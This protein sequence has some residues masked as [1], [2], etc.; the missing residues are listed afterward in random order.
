[1]HPV[2]REAEHVQSKGASGTTPLQQSNGSFD[3]A[4]SVCRFWRGGRPSRRW[5]VPATE[6]FIA[7]CLRKRGWNSD[8]VPAFSIDRRD[9]DD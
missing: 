1:M 4:L 8:G 5:Q 7:S 2:G 9:H 6:P 3:R